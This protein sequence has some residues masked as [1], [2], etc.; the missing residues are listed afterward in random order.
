VSPSRVRGIARGVAAASSLAGVGLLALYQWRGDLTLAGEILTIWPPELWGAA[1]FGV[2]TVVA[3]GDRRAGL[4][5]FAVDVAFLF[6]TTDWRPL[7]RGRAESSLPAIPSPNRFR[8]VTWN[9]ARSPDLASLEPLMPD[10]CLF[11]ESAPVVGPAVSAYWKDFKWAGTLDP[12]IFSRHPFESVEM[13]L[14]GPWAPPQAAVVRLPTARVLLVNVRLVLPGI[15]RKVASPSDLI[16]LRRAHAERIG[17]FRRLS[18]LVAAARRSTGGIPAI[19]CGDFNT[20]ARAASV[21]AL[22]PLA[23]VWPRAGHGWGGT[24]G[25][26]L[27]IARIDQCWS[28]DGVRPLQA[29]VARGRGSDHR[30]L[31]VDFAVD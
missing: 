14:V 28:S 9:V 11:Q 17:Q 29:F 15:V 2:A 26:D 4:V 16:D 8:L 12:A 6:A 7:M 22:W 27:P 30:L 31:V 19:V 5:V 13:E 1:L 24:M 20:A 18:E 3:L 21:Q 25:D 23:D 10:V